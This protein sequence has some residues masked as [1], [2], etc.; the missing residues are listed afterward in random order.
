MKPE[1]EVFAEK[2]QKVL[3]DC[4]EVKDLEAIFRDRLTKKLEYWIDTKAPGKEVWSAG[5]TWAVKTGRLYEV[6]EAAA[7]YYREF[8]DGK[9]TDLEELASRL[10]PVAPK[11]PKEEPVVQPVEAALPKELNDLIREYDRIPRS[12]G[13][14]EQ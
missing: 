11:T 9:K 3:D 14:K 10:R 4:L 13:E 2:W 5:Y 8:L 7:G 1:D 12:Y 6:T